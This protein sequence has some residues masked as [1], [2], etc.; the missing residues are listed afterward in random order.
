MADL[1]TEQKHAISHRGKVLAEFAD[2][3]ESLFST[4]ELKFL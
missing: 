3:F 4:S 1:T 2:D